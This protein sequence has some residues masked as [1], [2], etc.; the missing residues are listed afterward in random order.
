[1]SKLAKQ[2]LALT[3]IIMMLCWGGCALCSCF[4]IT[5]AEYPALYAPYLIGGFSP[6]IAAFITM[7]KHQRVSGFR[8]WLRNIFDFRHNI[9]SYLLVLILAGVFFLALC[10]VSGYEKGAPLFALV[11]M[12]PMML[13]GGG[14]E[15]AGW[16]GVLQPELEGKYG[17]AIATIIVAVIWWLWHLPL[18]FI[19]GVSQYGADFIEFGINVAGLSFALA[20]IRRNSGSTWLCILFHCIINSLHGIF[21]ISGSRV[22]SCAASAALILLSCLLVL[23]QKKKPLFS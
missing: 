19:N 1:M 14:L 9:F 20:A 8:E 13:F 5:L 7:K 11:F 6:T 2:F 15:E 16:R 3:F 18:F 21:I 23:V 4:G 22:G 17:F 10:L 12:V